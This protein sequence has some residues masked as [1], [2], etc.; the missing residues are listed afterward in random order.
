MKT[1]TNDTTN[2]APAVRVARALR[3]SVEADGH[4]VVRFLYER[5]LA[6]GLAFFGGMLPDCTV[7]LSPPSSPRALGDHCAADEHGLRYRVR[8]APSVVRGGELLLADVLLHELV[9]VWCNAAGQPEKG[10][11]GHGPAFAAACNKIG[12]MIGLPAVGVRGRDGLPDCAQWPLNV[13][14]AGYYDQAGEGGEGGE[15]GGKR[16]AKGGSPRSKTRDRSREQARAIA[17]IGDATSAEIVE[18]VRAI[19]ARLTAIAAGAGKKPDVSE[20]GAA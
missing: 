12:E 2:A 5:Y 14:P 18:V 20:L 10:Y 3:E 1:T 16:A 15:T 19:Q 7:L 11:R 9:H 13:R 17:F 6:F 8:I 4:P